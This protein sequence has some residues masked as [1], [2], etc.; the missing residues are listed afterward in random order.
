MML[1]ALP[2]RVSPICIP[3]T[4][5]NV[6]YSSRVINIVLALGNALHCLELLRFS[7]AGCQIGLCRHR[8]LR[9]RISC[10]GE[11]VVCTDI[12]QLF[13]HAVK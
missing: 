8:P 13:M 1:R 11:R 12:L 4:L 3:D 6:L 5:V 10:G 7:D 9:A 2:V